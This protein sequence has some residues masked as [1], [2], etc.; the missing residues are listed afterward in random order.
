MSP[1]VQETALAVVGG[2]VALAG[3]LAL[4]G[5]A[6]SAPDALANTLALLHDAL[7]FT[8]GCPAEMQAR[9]T[10]RSRAAALGRRSSPLLRTPQDA[11]ARLCEAWWH[12]DL[13]RKQ[14]LISKTVPFV[15]FHAL[16]YAQPAV[17]LSN[18]NSPSLLPAARSTGKAADVKRCHAVRG[19]LELFDYEDEASIMGLRQLLL[20]AAFAPA[21][22]RS[23][24]GRRFLSAL[25]TLHG[26][27]TRALYGVVREQLPCARGA[28]L[29]HYAEVLFRAWRNACGGPAAELERTVLAGLAASSL[30]AQTPQL[31][32][33]CRRL[34]S[35]FTAA[36]AAPGVDAA[37]MR[38]YRPTLFRALAAAN[39]AVRRNAAAAL[40]EVFPLQD[41]EAGQDESDAL[42]ARQAQ[43][44]AD[45]LADDAPA[46]RCVAVAGVA[47]VLDTFWELVPPKTTA[48]YAAKLATE[49]AC[50]ASSPAVRCAVAAGLARLVTN[51]ASQQLLKPLLPRV[52]HL[53]SDTSPSVR[54]AFADLL[55]AVRGVRAIKFFEVLPMDAI[56]SWLATERDAKTA[57]KLT[58]L[59]L[60]TYF[61]GG[62]ALA[63]AARRLMSLAE[64]SPAAAAAFARRMAAAGAPRS[65][66]KALAALMAAVLSASPESGGAVSEDAAPL[67]HAAPAKGRKRR[68][69]TP[70]APAAAAPS[71]AAT[72]LPMAVWESAAATLS[73]LCEGFALDGGALTAGRPTQR[74]VRAPKGG[75]ATEDERCAVPEEEEEENGDGAAAP[76]AAAL[77]QALRCA[78]SVQGRAAVL[79]AGRWLV[80]GGGGTCGSSARAAGAQAAPLLAHCRGALFAQAAQLDDEEAGS[81]LAGLCA[82]GGAEELCAALTAALQGGPYVSFAKRLTG[83]A[84]AAAASAASP[85]AAMTP[86]VAARYCGLAFGDATARAALLRCR[87]VPSLLDALQ[88]S[89]LEGLAG[90]PAH[91]AAAAVAAA[92]KAAIHAALA[93]QD[94]S[95]ASEPVN[96]LLSAALAAATTAEQPTAGAKR[97]ASAPAGRKKKAQLADEEDQEG[98]PNAHVAQAVQMALALAV[99]CRVRCVT[100]LSHCWH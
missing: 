2:C 9:A 36:K 85:Y 82:W 5:D 55:L 67:A 68:E 77:L 1:R 91:D 19:A 86:C 60:P 4:Q 12:A 37:L 45:L 30:S 69:P 73:E 41:P 89:A 65:A 99:R 59:L 97:K 13:P 64:A 31:A 49:L 32:A 27:V 98:L 54:A 79:R 83:K 39:P 16:R 80:G 17:A 61:P 33:A 92:G 74:Q 47:G 25:F 23:S 29:D 21:F 76:G 28:M 58:K 81:L 34:L 78:P 56:L 44:F 70:Q 63:E 10:P 8:P 50:D 62:A 51:P 15:I 40:F 100:A 95:A 18:P 72:A 90:A 26:G 52:A 71:S 57:V 43:A 38:A 11:V 75:D 53:A 14:E 93:E 48:G 20:R 24:E 88:T 42:M 46:V 84:P 94:H 6:S 96:A 35:G 3:A 66:L 22:L 7:L 87:G